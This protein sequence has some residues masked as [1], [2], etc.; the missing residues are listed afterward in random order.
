MLAVSLSWLIVEM[1]FLSEQRRQHCCKCADAWL[2]HITPG[3]HTKDL[4]EGSTAK[5]FCSSV[6]RQFHIDVG[7]VRAHNKKVYCASISLAPGD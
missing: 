3:A 2:F 1:P 5:H 4:S 6:L 7:N